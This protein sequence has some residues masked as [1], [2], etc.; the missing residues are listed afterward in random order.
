MKRKT[1]FGAM[2]LM[3]I[4]YFNLFSQ[5]EVKQVIHVSGGVYEFSSPY[6]DYVTISAYLPQS[7]TSS[8]VFDTIFTQ[9]VQDVVVSDGMAYVTAQD[10]L[11]SYNI[12]NYQRVNAIALSGINLLNVWNDY[13]L[14]G[15]GNGIGS[16]FFQIYD[17]NNLQLVKTITEITD[18]TFGITVNNDFA[19]IAIPGNWAST[20]GKVAI[21]DLQN[22]QYIKEYDLDTLGQGIRE[23]F[24]HNN[25]LITLNTMSYGAT[26]GVVSKID[27]SN[28]SIEHTII[29]MPFGN[30]FSLC[31]INV[32]NHELYFVMN[33]NIAAFD[34]N[35]KLLSDTSLISFTE[36]IAEAI[37]DTINNLFYITTTDYFSYG[38]GYVYDLQGSFLENFS[39]GISTQALAVDYRNT[40]NYA[41]INSK[42]NLKLYPNP[43]QDYITIDATDDINNILIFD[44]LGKLHLNIENDNVLNISILENGYY[45]AKI[46]FKNNTS[47]TLKFLKN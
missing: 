46:N 45:F 43:S 42:Y 9:S 13:L 16:D 29:D 11:I 39:V 10:S 33:G 26:Y 12:D 38:N 20:V 34:L 8:F 30:G 17:A 22:L 2:V 40:T 27:L 35:T 47:K 5:T 32:K 31:G 6:S 24:V 3:T 15:R 21:V 41:N 44:L 28:D 14:V 23:I 36:T 19:Y 4:S 7:D 1:I 18:E 37:F 25:K